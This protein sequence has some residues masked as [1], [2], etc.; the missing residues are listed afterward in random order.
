MADRTLA[1]PDRLRL[2]PFSEFDL[3]IVQIG[4]SCELVDSSSDAV[5]VDVVS[6]CRDQIIVEDCLHGPP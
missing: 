5:L 3:L 1:D 2:L 6:C 4:V